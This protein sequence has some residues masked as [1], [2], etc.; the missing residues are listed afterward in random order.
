MRTRAR[1][2]GMRSMGPPN[3]LQLWQRCHGQVRDL[4]GIRIGVE[5]K[6]ARGQPRQ[7]LAYLHHQVVVHPLALARW[8]AAP[9]AWFRDPGSYHHV[10]ATVDEELDARSDP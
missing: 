5:D 3:G 1:T 4:V 6:D 7:A 8:Q 10:C 9:R 2:A